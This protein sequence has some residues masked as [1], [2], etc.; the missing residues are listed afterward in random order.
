[1][2]V[3]YWC[4]SIKDPVSGQKR[5]PVHNPGTPISSFFNPVKKLIAHGGSGIL[6]INISRI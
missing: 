3:L 2:V 4:R 1:M 6:K 5:K